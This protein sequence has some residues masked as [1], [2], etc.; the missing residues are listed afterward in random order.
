MPRRSPPRSCTCATTRPSA[1]GWAMRRRK[2]PARGFPARSCWIAWKPFSIQPCAKRMARR[3]DIVT[4]TLILLPF[5]FLLFI[6]PFPGTVALR[7]VCLAAAFLVAVFLWRKLAPPRIPC[8]PAL[9]AWAAVALLS[10]AGAVDPAYSLGEIKNEVLYAMMTF[11]AFFAATRSE[12][13]LKQ[14]LLALVAG[15][16]LICTLALESRLRLGV[17]NDEGVFGGIAAF[18]GYAIALAPMLF[19]LGSLSAAPWRRASALGVFLLVDVT[20]FLS[21]QRIVW[22]TLAL[23]AGIA[24]FLLWRCGVLKMKRAAL[25]ACLAGIVLLAAGIFLAAQQQRFGGDDVETVTEDS[26]LGHWMPVLR[27]IAESPVRGAGFGRRALSKAHPDL[28][29]EDNT[30]FWHAH[31]VFLNYGLEMGV[32]GMLALA[33]VFV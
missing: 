24:V 12:A 26:R 31:N 10:L 21:L 8:R 14:L 33:W 9:F 13:D 16:L 5:M 32:P 23:Q 1:R 22:W 29:P 4:R 30:L 6:L 15:A 18:A 2:K 27:R 19:L 3:A 11:V 7:L 25:F 17:W 20:A 28:I